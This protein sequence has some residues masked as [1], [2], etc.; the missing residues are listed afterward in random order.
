MIRFDMK[1]WKPFSSGLKTTG[2]LF[3]IEELEL[4][5]KNSARIRFEDIHNA[6]DAEIF[7]GRELYLPVSML[8]PL[9]GKKFY[10]HEVIGFT[11][12][13]KKIRE[14]RNHHFYPRPSHNN[15]LCRSNMAPGKF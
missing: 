9:K 4:K 12:F 13:D 3:S 8:P 7:T 1:K 6:E 11:V 15:C 5:Q 10:Y 2:F 14:Y